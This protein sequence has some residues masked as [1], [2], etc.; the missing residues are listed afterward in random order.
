MF[1]IVAMLMVFQVGFSLSCSAQE[2]VSLFLCL[3]KAG[4]NHQRSGNPE[5]FESITENRLKNIRSGNL[6]QAEVNGKASYQSDVITLDMDIPIPG[7]VFPE[8]PKDQY[9]ISLDITQSIY[10]GGYSKNKQEVELVSKEL[11]N[12]QLE[13]DIRATKMQV[14]D[15][16]YNILLIQNNQ[17]IIGVSLAQL[18]ENRTVIETGIKNGVLLTTDLDLLEVEIIKLEQ[19]KSELENSRL[20][21][22][23][24]L[25]HMTGEFIGSATVLETTSFPIPENDSIQ[26]MEQLLFL[27]Q[28]Q[29]LDRNKTLIKSRSLPKVYAFGQFGYGNPALNMLKDEFE[30]YYV[31]GAGVKWTIWDWNT[32]KREREVLGLQQNIVES[33]QLQFESDIATALLSQKSV[34]ENHRENLKAYESILKLRSRIT[35]TAKAQLE[36]GVIKTLDYITVFN[37]ETIARIQFEN[38]K[39]LLQQSIARYLEI[40]GEL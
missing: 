35:S 14:K 22:I 29:Q 28:S 18:Y 36:Q 31:V 17:E 21:G 7:I 40:K 5:I 9:K 33:R 25:S 10:D 6:P 19:Q 11:D 16:Y 30:P 38:E 8:S 15:L 27:L 32:N 24:M 13:M 34:I 2:S 39:T 20:T 12:S 37:Q 1:R 26:R 4:R 3:E 23:Q